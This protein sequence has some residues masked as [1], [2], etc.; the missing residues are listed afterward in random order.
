MRWVRLNFESWYQELR[1]KVTSDPNLSD[2]ERMDRVRRGPSAGH[3]Q[4]WW[5]MQLTDLWHD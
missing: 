4:P 5:M 2:E 3:A 1:T